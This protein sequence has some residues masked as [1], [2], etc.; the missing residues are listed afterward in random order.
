MKT[1]TKYSAAR[2][3]AIL[4][5][6]VMASSAHSAVITSSNFSFG[7]GANADNPNTWTLQAPSSNTIIGN[8]TFAPAVTG[9]IHSASGPAFTNRVLTTTASG[10][11]Y[12]GR[13]SGPSGKFGVTINASWS[14]SL[15]AIEPG[16]QLEDVRLTLVITE[17]RIYGL[18]YKN[19]TYDYKLAF[20]ETTAGFLGSSAQVTLNK[21]PNN[22]DANSIRPASAYTL[23]SWSPDDAY[24][25]G[26]TNGSRS[27][28]LDLTGAP[29]DGFATIDGF[30]VFGYVEVS[31]IP[32]PSV[33]GLLTLGLGVVIMRRRRA[34]DRTSRG[35]RER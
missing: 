27:F 33:V 5:A 19:E 22:G 9:T 6:I 34:A 7:Y 24:F 8:F 30:E 10:N 32:E 11:T 12:S 28:M 35:R 25:D 23:L 13:N 21:I 2:V 4:S 3:A 31:A 16:L 17:I 15:N 1:E 18:Q 26:V 14:G 29:T 20:E